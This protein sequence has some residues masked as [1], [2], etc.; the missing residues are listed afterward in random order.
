MLPRC[1][2]ALPTTRRRRTPHLGASEAGAAP[3][4]V[5]RLAGELLAEHGIAPVEPRARRR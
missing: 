1:V 4:G 5:V 3:D 2:G